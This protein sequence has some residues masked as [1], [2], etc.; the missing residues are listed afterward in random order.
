MKNNI[1]IPLTFFLLLLFIVS[2]AGPSS[3]FT[4]LGTSLRD[5]KQKIPDGFAHYILFISPSHAYV[6]NNSEDKINILGKAFMNFKKDIGDD[7]YALWCGPIINKKYK[8][9][10]SLS[11]YFAD[12]YKLDYNDGPFIVITNINPDKNDRTGE[13]VYFIYF[14]NINPERIVVI[15][16]EVEREL[17]TKQ[18]IS[19]HIYDVMYRQIIYSKYN[20][21]KSFIS[22]LVDI[23]KPF[24]NK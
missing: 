1:L 16:N 4:H 17:R 8:F 2:C 11:K 15:L 12:K 23:L 7:N 21:V 22:D 13:E 6:D 19:P 24:S 18:N 20:S 5:Q 14:S 9:N 3:N 10:V